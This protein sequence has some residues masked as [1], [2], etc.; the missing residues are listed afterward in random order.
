MK[1]SKKS[2]LKKNMEINNLYEALKYL[3]D[4]SRDLTTITGNDDQLVPSYW[5]RTSNEFSKAITSKTVNEYNN[6]EHPNNVNYPDKITPHELRFPGIKAKFMEIY[7]AFEDELSEPF[8]KI[9][10]EGIKR[11]NDAWLKTTDEVSEEE[12]NFEDETFMN[13]IRDNKGIKI[14]IIQYTKEQRRNGK[15]DVELPL[16]GLY[17]AAIYVDKQ[18]KRKPRYPYTILYGIYNCFKYSVPPERLNSQINSVISDIYDRREELL[19]KEKGKITS[20]MESVKA[21]IAPLVNSNREAFS[22]ILEQIDQ[23]ISDITDDTI[24]N[25]AEQCNQAINLF[26]NN[27]SKSLDQVISDLTSADR[28]KVRETMDR[29]GLH[30]GNIRA[31]VDNVSG[32]MSNDEL[33]ASIPQM[34]EIDALINS[35]SK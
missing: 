34:S 30:E 32:G 29:V 5:V 25:I 9:T 35:T 21:S 18:K 23:G 3:I 31:L 11:V 6:K 19:T 12:F 13:S 26:E 24:D 7:E 15:V 33:K 20:T 2:F 14:T 10:D 28:E 4:I 8:L 1:I 17:R 27:K 16:S 22:G